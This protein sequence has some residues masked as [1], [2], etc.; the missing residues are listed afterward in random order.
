MPWVYPDEGLLSRWADFANSIFFPFG[1]STTEVP[2]WREPC[3]CDQGCLKRA[4][5]EAAGIGKGSPASAKGEDPLSRSLSFID[6]RKYIGKEKGSFANVE[7]SRPR[8]RPFYFMGKSKAVSAL[9]SC[10]LVIVPSR[11]LFS[12]YMS[13]VGD[14]RYK[15]AL[16]RISRCILIS[17]IISS[18]RRIS[19][20]GRM[21]FNARKQQGIFI[22]YSWTKKKIRHFWWL[23]HTCNREAPIPQNLARILN[24]ESRNWRTPLDSY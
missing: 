3:R 10:Q 20:E 22:Q 5:W 7:G 17:S 21:V 13:H 4:T 16:P 9:I 8:L 15:M 24:N 6:V 14:E 2:T 12:F 11:K 18:I 19:N 23:Q 1:G